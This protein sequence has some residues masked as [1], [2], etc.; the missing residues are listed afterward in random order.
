MDVPEEGYWLIRRVK[1]GPW[2]PARI[3]FERHPEHS[4]PEPW[5]NG[6]NRILGVFA[7]VN[8]KPASP[9][10]VWHTRGRPIDAREY[11]FLLQDIEWVEAYAPH[12]PK[13][14]PDKRVDLSQAEMPF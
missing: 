3:W 2:I 4:A 10:S 14:N 1:G 8:G 9:M 6:E 13:A 7:E 11:G 12:D 5:E